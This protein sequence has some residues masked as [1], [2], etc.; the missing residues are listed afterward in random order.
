[1][2]EGF[3]DIMK[4]TKLSPEETTYVLENPE[5][6][7]REGVD[8]SLKMWKQSTNKYQKKKFEMMLVHCKKFTTSGKTPDGK[9]I[10][11]RIDSKV[12]W[13]ESI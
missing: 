9:T 3:V 8:Y 11:S 4:E 2:T 5:G 12:T 10:L 13:S 7:T 6:L 1:M